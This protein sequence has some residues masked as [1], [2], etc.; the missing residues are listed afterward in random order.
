MPAESDSWTFQGLQLTA[1]T[2]GRDRV[3]ATCTVQLI[4]REGNEHAEA[5]IGSGPVEATFKAIN[6]IIQMCA[7]EACSP[8]RVFACAHACALDVAHRLSVRPSVRSSST[9]MCVCVCMCACAWHVF[10][11]VR[12]VSLRVSPR[13]RSPVNLVQ[14][15]VNAVTSG[16]DALGGV[17]VHIQPRDPSTPETEEPSDLSPVTKDK[18]IPVYT[19][20]GTSTGTRARRLAPREVER[21]PWKRAW[22]DRLNVRDALT[23]PSRSPPPARGAVR[24]ADIIVASAIS[25]VSALNKLIALGPEA[26]ALKVSV[27]AGSNDRILDGK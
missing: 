8:S 10:L 15:N 17:L 22:T 9:R 16:K 14:Y 6:R 7:A 2:D 24:R 18:R 5:A 12:L 4:D 20:H 21:A 1:G 11:C 3:R 27:S 13:A 25:Y 23:L 19:G 26:N